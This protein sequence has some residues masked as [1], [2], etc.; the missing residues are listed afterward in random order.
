MDSPEIRPCVSHGCIYVGQSFPVAYLVTQSVVF[1]KVVL[2]P[3]A[4]KLVTCS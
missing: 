2:H 1:V 4:Y 3:D